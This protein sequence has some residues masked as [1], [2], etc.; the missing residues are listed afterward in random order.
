[1][2]SR[3]AQVAPWL[4]PVPSAWAVFA[5]V[6]AEPLEW[7]WPVAVI[8]G[9]AVEVCGLAAMHTALEQVA[10]NERKLES[11]EP[12]DTRSGKVLVAL[13]FVAV[14]AVL[15]WLEGF[16]VVL[17]FPLLSLAGTLN[18]ALIAQQQG[19][20]RRAA[21]ALQKAEEKQAESNRKSAETRARNREAKL[22]I[23]AE[24][25]QQAHEAERQQHEREAQAAQAL[26]NF[27]AWP[28]VPTN[29]RRKIAAMKS[30]REIMDTYGVSLRT[31]QNWKRYAMAEMNGQSHSNLQEA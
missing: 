19:R 15:S 31:A 29:E 5:A 6:Y 14:Y 1:M 30:T 17:V 22:R 25:E 12:A 11:D 3:I 8:T 2:I 27:G 16:S 9:L 20:E 4:A 18:L 24:I 10:W 23:Q 26:R 21:E 7:P 28:N 13:Y